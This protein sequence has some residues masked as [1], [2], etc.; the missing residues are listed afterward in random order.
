V[1]EQRARAGAYREEMISARDGR[2]LYVR[3]YDTRGAARTPLLCLPGF[4]RDSRDFHA[5]ATHLSGERRVV[6]PDL[7]GRGR[8]ERDPDVARYAPAALLEDVLDLCDALGLAR[9]VVLG[10]SFGGFLAMGIGAARPRLL[11]GVILNDVGPDIE[12]AEMARIAGYIA[13][14]RPQPDWQAALAHARTTLGQGWQRQDDETWLRLARQS[15]SKAPDGS[16]VLDH[17]PRIGVP[18]QAIMKGG[19][20]APDLWRLWRSLRPIPTLVLR[21]ALSRI[22]TEATLARMAAE[23]PDL[24]AVR[25]PGIGH[26]PL[27]DEAEALEAIDGFL[28]RF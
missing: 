21:G 17:D 16:L 27:L 18:L 28:A 13:E 8:S 26:M 1:S 14:H 12:R 9:A 7:R 23:K 20:D 10:A 4:T 6:C 11:A 19:R 24:I 3:D 15:Y 2:R 5:L 25:V 22:L